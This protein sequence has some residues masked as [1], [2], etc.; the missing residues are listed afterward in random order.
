MKEARKEEQA[1]GISV[2][3]EQDM[4]EWYSQV[5]LK[6]GLADYGPVKGTMVIR[7]RG[8]YIWQKIQDYFNSV[9]KKHRVENAYFPL[10]IPKSF[11]E[12]EAQ[13][14]TGFKAEVAWIE[15]KEDGEKVALR[16]TSETIMYDS[17][18]KW[19][20]SYRD[21]PLRINQWCNIVRWEVSDCKLFLR[22]REFLWQEGHCVYETEKECDKEVLLFLDEYEKLCKELLA[23][24]VLKGKKTEKEKF[25]GAKYTT[26]IESLMPDG[27]ALQCGT[28]HNLGQGFAKSFN[29][30]FL[31][32]SG[33][34]KL[35]WQSS[36]GF[37]TRLIGATVMTH[38]DDR[39][40]VL[41]PKIAPL[42]IV[43][44]PIFGDEKEK[45][46]KKAKEILAKLKKYEIKLDNREDYTPG[47]KFNEYEL[48]GVPLRIELGPRDIKNDSVVLV[49]RD[50]SEK[51]SVKIKDIE[52]EVDKILEDIHNSLYEKAKNYLNSNIKKAKDWKEFMKVIEN[53]QIALVNFCGDSSCEDNIKYDSGGAG[54][55]LIK[56]DGS[57]KCFKCG[58]PAKQLVYFA[59]SY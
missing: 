42:Q 2:K 4:P 47:F 38:S 1:K 33:D 36:W 49:R 40:L 6:S 51:K 28:S 16:P 57:G 30:S 54:S 19:I 23:L 11:F 41:P 37:S 12:K 9:I 35:P 46:E 50:N 24:P 27:K 14:A 8:Y 10:F 18:S 7:P 21:L 53:R 5:C 31:D 48:S 58:K 25:A 3:K 39:G 22:S 45:V 29:I 32:K 52:K 43:I 34:K 56:E 55:R 59:K 17:Y 26:T 15:K 13:H 20:R 44:I